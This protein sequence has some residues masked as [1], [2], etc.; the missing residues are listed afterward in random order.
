MADEKNQFKVTDRRI[1]G[2]DGQLLEPSQSR[3]PEPIF[4]DDVGDLLKES[5]GPGNQD[6]A[7]EMNF[8][9]LVISLSTSA[10]VQLGVAPNPANGKTEKDLI[11]AKQ[12]IE[13]LAVLQEKTKG[14]LTPE[15]SRLLDQC[16][17]DL[18]MSY[19]NIAKK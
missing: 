14:N 16:L 7:M 6:H 8:Q 1:F 19:V 18:K 17:Y 2:S 4:S 15:E 13:I 10:L 11:S 5:A 12:T 9:M 3:N